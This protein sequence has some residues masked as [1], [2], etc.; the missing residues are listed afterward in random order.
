[1]GFAQPHDE[2]L[3]LAGRA[4]GKVQIGGRYDHLP[5]PHLELVDLIAIADHDVVPALRWIDAGRQIADQ[6]I[7]LPRL[8]LP[9]LHMLGRQGRYLHAA[10][11]ESWKMARST[12]ASRSRS[13]SAL[14]APLS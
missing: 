7:I 4:A 11:C 9:W 8:E 10:P 3:L 13:A 2:S 12:F 14:L 6:L 5:F 1:M